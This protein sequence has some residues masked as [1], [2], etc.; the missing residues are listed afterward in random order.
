MASNK[1]RIES[2]EAGLGGLREGMNRMELGVAKLQQMEETIN[3]L[4]EA[5]FSNKEG[6]SNNSSS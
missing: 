4:S 5:L 1:E 2:L 3:R 6:S